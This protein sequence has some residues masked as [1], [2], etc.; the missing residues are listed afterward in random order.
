MGITESFT[1]VR[2]MLRRRVRKSAVEKMMERYQF[3]RVRNLSTINQPERIEAD[4]GLG[5]GLGGFFQGGFERYDFS[6]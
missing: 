6:F 1:E 2:L 5:E 4:A 3:Q